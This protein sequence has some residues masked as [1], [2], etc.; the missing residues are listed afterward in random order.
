[1]T[2]AASTY[3]AHSRYA[4]SPRRVPA[5]V[6]PLLFG[7]LALGCGSDS[8]KQEKQSATADVAAD[9]GVAAGA[10]DGPG[11]PD[12]PGGATASAPLGGLY[13][14][15]GDPEPATL[16]RLTRSE[17][18]HSL[19]D[20]LGAD[21]PIGELEPDVL[22]GGFS[23]I[24]AS[25]V[26]VSPAGV[27]LH[28]QEVLDA[29]GFLFAD[30]A[31]VSALLPCVPAGT[32]DSECTSRIVAQFGRRAFR[33]P[34]TDDE[35]QRFAG[36]AATIGAAPGAGELLGL[37]YALAA[38][39]QSPSFIYR[40]E[41]GEPSAADGGRLKYTDFEM[42]SRLAATLWDSVPDDAL[43]DAAAAGALTTADGLESQADRLLA[44]PRA[45]R[46]IAVFTTELFGVSHL[47]QAEKDDTLFPTWRAS[48]KSA[49]REEL[50]RRVLDMV[51]VQRGDFLSLY[52]DRKTFVNDDL[53]QFYG[54]PAS[55]QPGFYPAEFPPESKRAGLLG[56][57]AVLAS[58]GLPQRNSPTAR[59]KFVSEMVLCRSIPPPP[60]NVPPLPP[61]AGPDVTMRERLAV[62]RQA[63]V[64]ASCHS[65]MDP[66]GFG[67][68]DFD[69][70]GL[71][72]TMEG[73]VPVDASGSLEG[74]GLDGSTFEGLAELGAALRRQPV[75]APC[76][77]SKVYS[78][79][80][81]RRA[82]RA[83]GESIEQLANSFTQRQN[84]LDQ[85]LV[86]LVT[87]DSFR[88]AEPK[89]ATP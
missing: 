39:L 7:S 3:R 63:A 69:S 15:S 5:L 45:Q 8:S 59:G 50:E 67:M 89:G 18:V 71:H 1:M 27:G 10:A 68:E 60:N 61:Q 35:V 30:P 31:R 40:V 88:F 19:Q 2:V 75:V 23:A 79:A 52:E 70:A 66:I 53:A 57:G 33:R 86:A 17:L 11:T 6:L 65:M 85:L 36:L 4:S 24:G 12:S 29:T 26:A 76:L 87:S 20:L 55:G 58:H 73:T 62:H 54:L 42:A 56:A 38:I 37:R 22:V 44:D 32:A 83:D 74:P 9:G 82:V 47:E 43:L 81:G 80:L 14:A 13:L 34:L 77:V 49:M 78:E 72:R 48:L 16:H 21:V 41:L 25:S 64:C 28:E 84:R 51:F 46:S